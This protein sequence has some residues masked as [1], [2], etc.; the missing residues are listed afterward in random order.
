MAYF[1]LLDYFNDHYIIVD[2]HWLWTGTSDPNGYGRVHFTINQN[3]KLRTTAHRLSLHL[4][5]G[6]DLNSYDQ[7]NHKCNKKNCVNPEHLYIGTQKDNGEDERKKEIRANVVGYLCSKGLHFISSEYDL[8]KAGKYFRCRKCHYI[9]WK[10][11]KERQK[12][13]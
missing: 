7:A 13:R 10:E 3:N 1:S 9:A 6:L 4:F 8:S 2:S 5:K 12:A 11:C